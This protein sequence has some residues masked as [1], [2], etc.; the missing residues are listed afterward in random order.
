MNLDSTKETARRAAIWLGNSMAVGLT[1]PDEQ[2][3]LLAP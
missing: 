2:H 1:A 3:L